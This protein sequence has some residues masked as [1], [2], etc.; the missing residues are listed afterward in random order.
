MS[1]IKGVDCTLFEKKKSLLKFKRLSNAKRSKI[2]MFFKAV[3]MQSQTPQHTLPPPPPPP[4]ETYASSLI[5]SPSSKKNLTTGLLLLFERPS[6]GLVENLQYFLRYW[7][8]RP[9]GKV[10]IVP[11][12]LDTCKHWISNLPLADTSPEHTLLFSP[13]YARFDQQKKIISKV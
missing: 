9:A 7:H 2:A 3:V 1:A 13:K 5:W 8:K 6:R 4:P 10:S 12:I 11:L